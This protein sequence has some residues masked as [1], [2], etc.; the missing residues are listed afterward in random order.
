M[1]QYIFD[2]LIQ[3][4]PQIGAYTLIALVV[5]LI[6]WKAA[7]FYIKTQNTVSKFP[8]IETVLS[9]IDKGFTTLNQVLLEKQ[10][11]SQSCYSNEN[12][13]RVV[14]EI[15]KKLFKESG[16]EELFE[17]IKEELMSELESK[18]FDS[19]LE[20]ERSC[21]NVLLEKMNDNRFKNIQNFAFQNPKYEGLPLS[22]TDMLFVM[23]LMLRDYYREKYPESNLG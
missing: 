6:V 11:I 19:L 14:N 22:Y 10:V 8:M 12:S 23:A 15:G 13:P 21:L 4:F 1:A 2:K 20:L 17:K 16:A 7:S 18:K 5:G 3:Y 9:K